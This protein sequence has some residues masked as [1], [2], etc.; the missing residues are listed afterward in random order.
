[1]KLPFKPRDT[2]NL[3]KA[4]DKA[5][6]DSESYPASSDEF[7]TIMTRIDELYGLRYPKLKKEKRKPIDPNNVLMIS[8]N[9]LGLAATLGY[10]HA[11]VIAGKS[12]GMI[13]KLKL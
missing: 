13:Q 11:H 4:I 2:T 1:M 6:L 7:A 8:A 12:F 9:L 10:E 5:F 3:D